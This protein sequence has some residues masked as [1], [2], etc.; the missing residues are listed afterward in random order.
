MDSSLPTVGIW[1]KATSEDTPKAAVEKTGEGL[2]S[3]VS[4]VSNNLWYLLSHE[5][6]T[7]CQTSQCNNFDMA[8]ISHLSRS[9]N[10]VKCSKETKNLQ[11]LNI[12]KVKMKSVWK[13]D[14]NA[15][16]DFVNH[17]SKP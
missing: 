7:T 6:E 17:K 10:V 12:W 5:K 16:T 8:V 13:A 4:E 9:W 2:R 3:E 1:A 14:Y 11:Y 15:L